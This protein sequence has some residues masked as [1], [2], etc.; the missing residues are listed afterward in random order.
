MIGVAPKREPVP[1]FYKLL[2]LKGTGEYVFFSGGMIKGFPE[3]ADDHRI[4]AVID[5]V[6]IFPDTVDPDDIALI[7]D[8]ACL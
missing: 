3:R 4:A 1:H 6:A 5:I 2:L 7:F 8:G